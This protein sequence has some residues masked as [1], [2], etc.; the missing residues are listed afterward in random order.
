M[1]YSGSLFPK[2]KGNAF[3]GGLSSR[4][5]VRVAVD[6]G[7]AKEL[8]RYDMGARIREIEQGP[9]G[10]LWILEDGGRL[11]KLDPKT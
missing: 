6:G 11:L 5:L 4:S 3:L 1:F 9:N 8:E 2:W 10:A 7:F